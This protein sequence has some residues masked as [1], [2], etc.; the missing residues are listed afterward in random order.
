V[1]QPPAVINLTTAFVVW[2]SHKH[3]A[4][5]QSDQSLPGSSLGGRRLGGTKQ[6]EFRTIKAASSSRKHNKRGK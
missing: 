2:T 3:L 4:T 6:W 5:L 1:P